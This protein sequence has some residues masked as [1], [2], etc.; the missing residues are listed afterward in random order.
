MKRH[1]NFKIFIFSHKVFLA[2]SLLR[3]KVISNEEFTCT[4]RKQL[5]CQCLRLCVYEW[6]A[7]FK[8]KKYL[9]LPGHTVFLYFIIRAMSG[10]FGV[11]SLILNTT[12]L[13]RMFMFSI[14]CL[15]RF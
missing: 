1:L 5:L 4:D 9:H 14:C 7:T 8:G 10:C 6:K 11:V 13:L 15:Y 2:S 3:R 12:S